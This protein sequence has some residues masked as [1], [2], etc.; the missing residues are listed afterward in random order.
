MALCLTKLEREKDT[1]T[2]MV[3]VLHIHPEKGKF[4]FWVIQMWGKALSSPTLPACI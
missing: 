2:A 1:G 3:E 4:F